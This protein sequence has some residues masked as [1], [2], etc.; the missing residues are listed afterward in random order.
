M[1]RRLTAIGLFVPVVLSGQVLDAAR[2]GNPPPDLRP[3]MLWFWSAAITDSTID[4][5]LA[6]MRRAGITRVLVT[7][8]AAPA[9]LERAQAEGRRAGID[10][11]VHG[12]TATQLVGNGGWAQ[13]PEQL[14][15]QI[16]AALVSNTARPGPIA[17]HAQWA[18][19]ANPMSASLGDIVTWTARVTDLIQGTSGAH[20]AVIMRTRDSAFA[21]VIQTLEQ[22][23]ASFDIVPEEAFS[24]GASMP[25]RV[26]VDRRAYQAALVPPVDSLNA[27]T[28][29]RL[30]AMSRSG[31]TVVAWRPLPVATAAWPDT[32][33]RF[34]VID[35]LPQLRH[36][37]IRTPWSAV[38]EP[39]PAAL[40]VRAIERGEDRVWALFNASDR[41]IAIAPTFRMIGQPEMWNPDDGKM[42]LAP[43]RWS[44]RMAVTD[45]PIELNPWQVL[46][47]VFRARPRSPRGPIGMPPIERTVVQARNDWRFRFAADTGWR[48]L[49]ALGSWTAIDSTYSGTGVYETSFAIPRL[50]S[51]LGVNER[52]LLD[53]GQ[54]RDVAEVELNGTP[55]GR[56]MW[57]PY[58]YDV[59]NIVKQGMNGIVVRVANTPA[60]RNGQPVPAGLLGPVRIIGVRAMQ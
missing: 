6:V 17:L 43:T 11:R 35:S 34:H 2:F 8:E 26:V 44:P 19:P 51:A 9:Q 33:P 1:I 58:R 24:S 16:A 12:D 53:L 38:R 14:R 41:R 13:T 23:Q 55:L 54:V 46:G 22:L 27:G 15:A 7:G 42:E 52:Y 36:A 40:R 18:D 60:N 32:G 10:V 30:K 3:A 31:G 57:R 29:G 21:R 28:V 25:G 4:A 37:L 59:T 47:I 20:M 45:V 49:T 50:L 5:Q 48:P 56:R 39:G